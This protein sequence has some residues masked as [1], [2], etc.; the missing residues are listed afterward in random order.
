MWTKQKVWV[1]AVWKYSHDAYYSQICF[2]SALHAAALSGHAS[3]VKI[4]LDHGA[5]IDAPDLLKHTPLFRACEMGHT[6]VVQTL[7]DYGA[8]VDVLDHDGRSSLHWWVKYGI[9]WTYVM[10]RLK[11]QSWFHLLKQLFMI[12]GKVKFAKKDWYQTNWW[13]WF[14]DKQNIQ[15]E[16]EKHRICL[17]S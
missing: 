7:I 14:L 2:L 13:N 17:L 10:N 9:L 15:Y 8:R 11:Q 3:T 12:W 5:L 16:K 1:Y 6:D 4:L